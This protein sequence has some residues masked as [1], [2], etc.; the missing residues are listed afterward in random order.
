M[1][2]SVPEIL[3]PLVQTI[4]QEVKDAVSNGTVAPDDLLWFQWKVSKLEYSDDGVNTGTASGTQFSRPS[5]RT[6]P[7]L[8]LPRITGRA[9]FETTL[10][11]L[12]RDYPDQASSIRSF[13]DTFISNVIVKVLSDIDNFKLTQLKTLCA[14]FL[15][16]LAGGPITYRAKVNL[17]G[18]VLRAQ[19]IQVAVGVSLRRPTREDIEIA[20]PIPFPLGLQRPFLS[21]PQAIVEI[22]YPGARGQ[23]VGLQREVEHSVS[24]LRLFGVGSV[25]YTSYEM[26]SSSMVEGLGA[27]CTMDSGVRVS[28]QER[29]VITHEDE[30][31]L[32][33]FWHT[34]VHAI[35][36]DIYDFQKQVS[37]L[38]LA[39]D[40]YSDAVLQNGIV[41]RRIAN[42]VMGLEAL[43]LDET[44]ELSY[45]LGARIAKALSLVGK[46]PLE[47]RQRIKDAYRIR[48]LFA[49]GGHLSYK[50]KAKYERRYG[51]LKNF[52]LPLFDYL[53]SLIVLMISIHCDKEQMID[54]IDDALIDSEKHDSL[55]SR[56]APLTSLVSGS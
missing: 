14:T 44:Q 32:K 40:R 39:Y 46:K 15:N 3:D 26:E 36:K 4:V 41:E 18:V 29:Y 28:A 55:K 30:D 38:T 34:M 25:V 31:R 33:R 2:S 16:D 54:W 24:I 17:K 42:A 48:S 35:P 43:L 53:R 6:A 56:V 8:L 45:R 10:D 9:V 20:S 1:E 5:W 49:H 50:D 22:Q 7:R 21:V 12:K 23:N 13:L 11:A 47:V 52:M 27:R 37:P 51:N 19:S